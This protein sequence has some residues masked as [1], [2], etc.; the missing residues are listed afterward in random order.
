MNTNLEALKQ[1]LLNL[2][3]PEEEVAELSTTKDA[4]NYFI[5]STGETEG[6]AETNEKALE[7]LAQIAPNIIGSFP[8]MKIE[9]ITTSEETEKL[10]FN[11]ADIDKLEWAVGI[12][13]RSDG[14]VISS[15]NT[16]AFL[17]RHTGITKKIVYIISV[18]GE[19]YRIAFRD[20]RL[21]ND[22]DGHY[23][24]SKVGSTV[25]PFSKGMW[26]VYYVTH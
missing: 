26:Q 1:M 17:Y 8:E 19:G 10:Y 3:S 25:I 23:F 15:S 14:G 18:S 13:Y 22:E 7:A 6:H 12:P 21:L 2:G 5:A 20:L 24:I 4:I 16:V 9:N 11:I